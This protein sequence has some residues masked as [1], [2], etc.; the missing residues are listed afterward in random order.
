[1]KEPAASPTTPIPDVLN[2][3]APELSGTQPGNMPLNDIQLRDIHLP[4]PV[5]WWPP[6]P[7]WWLALATIILIIAAVVIARKIYRSKQLSRDIG[8]ELEHIKQQYQ[9]S[10]NKPQ[11]ARDLSILL[12][13]ANISFYPQ[14]NI[15]GLTGE[16]WLQHLDSTN[17]KPR[18]E[19]AF[20]SETGKVL[21][22][23]PYMPDDA[24]PDFDANQLISLCESWLTSTHNKTQVAA[25]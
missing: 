9:Q 13:R 22:S 15:A 16:Q 24:E 3:G 12:R 4:E 18:T 19:Q 7:G 25:R 14:S 21:L 20:H 6:A 10:N 8:S 1:M 23:A 17:S 2:S 5:S 11:L